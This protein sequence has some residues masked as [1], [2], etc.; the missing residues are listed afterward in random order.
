MKLKQIRPILAGLGMLVLIL[1]AKNA[2]A[3]ASTG[4]RL[5]LNSVIPSLFPF[6]VLSALLTASLGE[7]RPKLLT[8][9]CR[10]AGIPDGG[11][12]LLAVALLGGYPVGADNVARLYRSGQLQKEEAQRLLMFCSNAGPAFLFGVVAAQF[13]SLRTVWGLWGILCLSSLTV[14]LLTKGTARGEIRPE[15][16]PLTVQAALAQSISVMARVCGWVVLFRILWECLLR[17]LFPD[18]QLQCIAGG[19]LELTAGCCSLDSITDEGLRFV[20]AAGLLSFGGVCVCLQT[21]AVTGTL[22]IA[23]YLRGKLLQCAISL[24]LAAF[25]VRPVSVIVSGP[26]LLLLLRSPGKNRLPT[27]IGCCIIHSEK[28]KE[29]GRYD[30]VPKKDRKTV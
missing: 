15:G 12:G 29:T 23:A 11:E 13:S 18:P 26:I 21:A 2:L 6:F 16:T 5:C 7:L 14:A 8:P 27:G 20:I 17:R 24:T 1:D 9:L 30:A 22:G 3:G 10:L 25:A 28:P 4:I 19:L